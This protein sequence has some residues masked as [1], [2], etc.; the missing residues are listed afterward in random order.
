MLK[1]FADA[2]ICIA[3]FIIFSS[4]FREKSMK[5]HAERVKTILVHKNRQKIAHGTLLFSK[6]TTFGK[7][8]ESPWVPR[9]LPG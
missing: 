9:E 5:K 3:F 1:K 6:K 4:I 8:L 2:H 7:F